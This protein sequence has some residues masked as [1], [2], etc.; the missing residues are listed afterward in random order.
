[1]DATSA[2]TIFATFIGDLGDVLTSNLPLV[3]AVVAG[4]IGLGIVLRYVKRW[5]GRK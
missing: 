3:L 1:M 4:L 5:I 2:G